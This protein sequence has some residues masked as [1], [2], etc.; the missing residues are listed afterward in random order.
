MSFDQLS[1]LL[2]GVVLLVVGKVLNRVGRKAH[3]DSLAEN[4][5][6]SL[7][8]N[9]RATEV[10]GILLSVLGCALV[11]GDIIGAVFWQ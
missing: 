7:R 10:I 5:A 6:L 9:L 2:L 11:I 1:V 4:R 8:M 3:Q